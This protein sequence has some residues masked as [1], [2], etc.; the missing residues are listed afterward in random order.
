MKKIRHLSAFLIVFL[1]SPGFIWGQAETTIYSTGFEAAEGFTAG[2]TY[3]NTSI[4]YDGPSGQQ[5]GTYYGTTSTTSPISG[6]IS[7]QMRWYTSAPSNLGYT[8]T[9][10]DLTNVTRV[11]FKAANLNAINVI[12]SYSTDGGS[13]YTGDQTYTLS[14]TSSEYEYIISSTGEFPSVRIK[15]Q[16]TYTTAPTATSRLYVD[17]VTVYGI[18]GGN[19]TVA[20]PQFTPPAGNYFSAQDVTIST[21]TENATIYYTTDGSNPDNTSTEY[22]EPINVSSTTILKAIAYADGFDP[23]PIATALYSFPLEVADIATLRTGLTD[24]TIYRLTG[25]AVLTY[26][27]TERNVK[28]IQDATGAIL[29]DDPAGIITTTYNLY[30]GITG[31]TG[32]LGTFNGML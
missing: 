24:G 30:D 2:T 31:I 17:D 16:L 20:T 8:F 13:T 18:T 15:F 26:Q 27:S 1:L 29:I 25:E 21:S 22:T 11:T 23:S 12:A 9:N 10:F 4:R 7:M 5:W 14:T 19:P 6:G 3:N 28:Y 32:T